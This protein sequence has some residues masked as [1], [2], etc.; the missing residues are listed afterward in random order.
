[1]IDM[2]FLLLVF[3]IL[4]TMYM[5]ETKTIEMRLPSA[6]NAETDSR[7]NFTVTVQAKGPLLLNGEAISM[8]ALIAQSKAMSGLDAKFAVVIMA[9]KETNYRQVV[10][11]LDK[12][13]GAGVTRVALATQTGEET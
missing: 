1:M 4:G 11:L 5:T 13:K 8:E 12:L 9:D 6:K 3:F 10:T 7:A 2:I